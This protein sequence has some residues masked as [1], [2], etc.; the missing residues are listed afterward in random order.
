[1][2]NKSHQKELEEDL[3]LLRGE[4]SRLKEENQRLRDACAQGHR[5]AAIWSACI[6]QL[7]RTIGNDRLKEIGFQMP[8]ADYIL[9]LQEQPNA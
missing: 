4:V 8:D 6:G 5:Q 1:M 9:S 3:A 2:P 7:C